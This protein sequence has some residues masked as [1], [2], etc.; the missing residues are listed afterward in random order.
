MTE[1]IITALVNLGVGLL[2]GWSGIAGFLLPMYFVGYL[3]LPVPAALTLS[4]FDF[5]LSGAIGSYNYYRK[6]NLNVRVSLTIGA[7]SL[8][9]ALLGVQLSR[10]IPAGTTKLL[11]YLVVL[12]SGIS[13]LLR[14]ENPE[15]GGTTPRRN[16]LDRPL[17]V[18]LIGVVTGAVC[19][20][21]GAGGPILVMPL[22]VV[23]GMNIRVAI[24][25]ALF[26]SILIAIPAFIGYFARCQWHDIQYLL[27]ICAV[28]HSLGVLAGCKSAYKIKQRPLKICVA[29]FSIA[30]ACYMIFTIPEV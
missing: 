12:L 21:S 8:T 3:K 28:F 7:G 17:P 4:F 2:L 1:I 30:I 27:I 25:V 19:S 15:N 26:D 5:G 24:G 6:G 29:I 9:G 14:S 22:L 18:V 20:L 11:L 13:I 10:L 23:M 16:L